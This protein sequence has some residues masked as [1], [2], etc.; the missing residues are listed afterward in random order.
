MHRIMS[1]H[2]V[3]F[4]LSIVLLQKCENCVF[5]SK[6]LYIV[7]NGTD[8]L[9]MSEQVDYCW[10]AVEVAVWPDES[11]S[12]FQPTCSLIRLSRATVLV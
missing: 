8:H 2:R 7:L 1:W 4:F 9:D 11:P 6:S 10:F 3:L 12:S 5:L